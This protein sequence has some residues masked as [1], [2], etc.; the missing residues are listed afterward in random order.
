M[1]VPVTCTEKEKEALF[2]LKDIDTA[3]GD[4]DDGMNMFGRRLAL[5]LDLNWII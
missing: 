2:G 3:W 5:S 1:T 4:D